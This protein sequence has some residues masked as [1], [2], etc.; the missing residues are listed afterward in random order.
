MKHVYLLLIF[1]L[2]ARICSAQNDFQ[3]YR[4]IRLSGNYL[5][6]ETLGADTTSLKDE[7]T[8]LLLHR[9]AGLSE[10]Q[11]DSIAV[12]HFVFPYGMRY[13]AVAYVP[14]KKK[15]ATTPATPSSGEAPATALIQ[16][17]N[18]HELITYLDIQ[19][20]KN[21]LAFTG[22]ENTVQNISNC[23]VMVVNKQADTVIACLSKGANQRTNLFNNEQ[24]NNFK[25]Q[26]SNADF[27][28]VYVF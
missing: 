8:K 14:L 28:W 19:A 22:K 18:Y 20:R 11:Q 21:K 1:L 27:I 7:S 23:Y 24:V 3:R 5:F 17:R 9:I 13:K 10:Y 15:P 4:N 25:V 2:P 16:F 6:E 26:F 12:E